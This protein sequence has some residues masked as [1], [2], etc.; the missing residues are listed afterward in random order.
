MTELLVAF[1]RP[2]SLT[3]GEFRSWLVG[4][5]KALTNTSA[6][7]TPEPRAQ[8]AISV[9]CLTVDGD[10]ESVSAQDAIG[11]LLGDMRMLGLRPDVIATEN[12]A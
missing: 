10:L 9:V 6:S 12:E 5:A 3:E 1:E 8:G 7:L 4:Y 11:A 2:A